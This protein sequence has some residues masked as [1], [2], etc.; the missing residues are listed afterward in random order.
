MRIDANQLHYRAL[1]QSIRQGVEQGETEFELFPE[2][3]TKFFLKIVDAQVVFQ[4]D[5]QGQVNM[6]TLFQGGEEMVG[7]KIKPPSL[8]AEELA[9]YEGSYYSEEVGT[10]YS[11][12]VEDS[13][14]V[15]KH[16]RH[17]DIPLSASDVDQFVGERW[18]FT[19][20]Q[21]IRDGEN[22][23]KGLKLSGGRVKNLRFDKK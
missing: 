13:N 20:V 7:E 10:T 4:K 22:T 11:I 2:S 6:F 18:F 9:E 1:N 12:V 16:R 17:E 21:F 8:T 5:E 3:E 19:N 15:A 23:V 14:L